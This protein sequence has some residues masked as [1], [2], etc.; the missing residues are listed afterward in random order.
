MRLVQQSYADL[1]RSRGFNF[2]VRDM[3]SSQ[4]EGDLRVPKVQVLR[5]KYFL[6]YSNTFLFLAFSPYFPNSWTSCTAGRQAREKKDISTPPPTVLQS[7]EAKGTQGSVWVGNRAHII[8]S[9]ASSPGRGCGIKSIFRKAFP[10]FH[11][12][13]TAAV[14]RRE[15]RAAAP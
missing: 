6:Y 15:G 8:W 5:I 12:H 7:A 11:I 4:H 3:I 10:C 9:H 14:M 2:S 13:L 1:N